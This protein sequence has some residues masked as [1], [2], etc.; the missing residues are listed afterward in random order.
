[1]GR[2]KSQVLLFPNGIGPLHVAD[3]I[4]GALAS[5]GATQGNSI[6]ALYLPAASV[7]LKNA[8]DV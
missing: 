7:S 2:P 5:P 4:N 1:V 6:V 8:S 3:E